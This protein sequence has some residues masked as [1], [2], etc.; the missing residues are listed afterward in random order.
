[1]SYIAYMSGRGPCQ[2]NQYTGHLLILRKLQW[3]AGWEGENSLVV[4]AEWKL[5]PRYQH[6][7][8]TV[9]HCTVISL[10]INTVRLMQECVTQPRS[11]QYLPF[12]LAALSWPKVLLLNFIDFPLSLSEASLILCMFYLLLWSEDMLCFC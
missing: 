10:T 9:F 5:S 8:V 12:S 7:Q 6:H 4:S 1:M 3:S 2:C 11:F